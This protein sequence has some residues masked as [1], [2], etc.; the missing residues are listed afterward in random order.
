MQINGQNVEEKVFVIA[1]IGSS[2][3]GDVKLAMRMAREAARAGV[4]AVKFHTYD[5][6]QLVRKDQPCMAHAAGD[7][8]YAYQRFQTLELTE[9]EWEDLRGVVGELGI[10][11]ISTPFDLTSADF[12]APLVPVFKISSGD[13]VFHPLLRL[14]ASTG[15]P[16]ILSTGMASEEEI[17][18]ALSIL[19]ADKTVLMHCVSKYPTPYRE[20]N[21][22]TI[23]WL[24]ERFGVTVG[25]SDHTMGTQA[26]LAAV[27]M[28]ARV[29][30]KHFT[31]DKTV[32]VGDHRLSADMY[33]MAKLVVDVRQL[34]VMLGEYGKNVSLD[35]ST[36]PV[37][38][39]S[40]V[41]VRSIKAGEELSEEMLLY[42]RPA[43]GIAPDKIDA[44]L[45]RKLVCDIDEQELILPKHFE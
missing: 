25:Y 4:D 19:G 30:E 16:A 6:A 28:G 15:K 45:G 39:R 41:A 11:F 22:R 23:P 20:A 2:H 29:I 17:E 35:A 13:I 37:M 10:G 3:G 36:V 43:D 7:H 26:C 18:S 32:A 1:E 38:R 14:V 9:Q 34:E 44:Y 40:A 12:L 33:D 27:A 5:S 24:K 21:L 8:Q 42:V 31:Y